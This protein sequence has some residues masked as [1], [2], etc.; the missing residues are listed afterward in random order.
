MA[1]LPQIL[2]PNTSCLAFKKRLQGMLKCMQNQSEEA[3]QA[4]EPDSDITQISE[5]SEREFKISMIA[6][7]M[8]LMEKVN[9]IQEQ[10][11]NVS[12][13]GENSN[14]ESK[15]VLDIFKRDTLREMKNTFDGLT[16]RVD[17]AKEIISELEEK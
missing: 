15:A 4:S 16:C 14:K 6:M 5:V 3:K 8:A 13:R 9:N 17:I 2:L 12:K 10:M 1:Y 7:L 11:G